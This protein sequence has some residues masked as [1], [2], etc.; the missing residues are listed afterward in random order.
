MSADLS[1]KS[2]IEK[3]DWL[4]STLTIWSTNYYIDCGSARVKTIDPITY[5][6]LHLKLQL[7]LIHNIYW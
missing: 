7:L 1:W 5:V 4:R 6:T 3:L 2:A